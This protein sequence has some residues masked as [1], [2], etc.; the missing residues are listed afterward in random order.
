MRFE[1]VIGHFIWPG[2]DLPVRERLSMD[3][4]VVIESA[5]KTRQIIL[6]RLMGQIR[7]WIQIGELESLRRGGGETEVG[8]LAT[9][10]D[11]VSLCEEFFRQPGSI[12]E[13]TTPRL[14]GRN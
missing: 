12:G 14:A 7:Y 5:D 3:K 10:E 13:L 2:D 11:A 8:R 4:A 1:A 9:P 6:Q